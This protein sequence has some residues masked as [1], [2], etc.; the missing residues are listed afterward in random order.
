[1]SQDVARPKSPAIWRWGFIVGGSAGALGIA[2]AVATL[3]LAAGVS[4]LLDA[5]FVLLV[6]ALY[7]VGGLMVARQ[8]G[9]VGAATLSGVV[10]GIFSAILR[11]IA[12]VF[13]TYNQP[14]PAVPATGFDVGSLRTVIVVISVLFVL[15]IFGGLGAG[16]AALGG[17]A[18]RRRPAMPYPVMYASMP[19]FPPQGYPMPPGYDPPPGYPMPP[20]YGPPPGY[21]IPQGY[22]PPPGYPVP[23]GFDPPG[24]ASSTYPS[25][26]WYPAAPAMPSYPPPPPNGASAA[27][28][29]R[30]S[31]PTIEPSMTGSADQATQSEPADAPGEA[32]SPAPLATE[33]P[34]YPPPVPPSAQQWE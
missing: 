5:V 17:L 9:S 10:A 11:E 1:M 3:A 27:P 13:I 32:F 6:L 7:F 34:A 14:L 15:L 18:G 4:L 33:Q 12:A 22:G 2:S 8:T 21:P 28:G 20:G 29:S 31:P 25:A 23:Q 24:Y 26:G 30:T 19:G 16:L